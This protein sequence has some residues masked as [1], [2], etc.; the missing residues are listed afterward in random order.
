MIKSRNV[1]TR[2]LYCICPDQS[3]KNLKGRFY[4]NLLLLV[5]HSFYCYQGWGIVVVVAD[6]L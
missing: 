4:Q 5:D 2:F 3:L 1:H 6:H